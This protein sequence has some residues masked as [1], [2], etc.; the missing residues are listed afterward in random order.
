MGATSVDILGASV[1]V[2]GTRQ[3]SAN[4]GRPGT[5]A[6]V[7]L[8]HEHQLV[9]DRRDRLSLVYNHTQQLNHNFAFEKAT[10]IG[11]ANKKMLELAFESWSS[12]DTLNRAICP[13]MFTSTQNGAKD[14]TLERQPTTAEEEGG[15][16]RESHDWRDTLFHGSNS[17][18]DNALSECQLL[19]VEGRGCKHDT[20]AGNKWD[21]DPPLAY[22]KQV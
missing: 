8:I 19:P 3:A 1:V 22:G 10:V 17:K 7:F 5:S 14:V 2:P 12:T 21:A 20:G 13:N 11:R 9:N 4:G 16:D 6:I 18:G 15:S